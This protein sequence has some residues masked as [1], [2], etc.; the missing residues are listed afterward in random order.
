M[1]KQQ[2]EAVVLEKE[3]QEQECSCVGWHFGVCGCY[4]S[5]RGFLQYTKAYT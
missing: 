2:V 5:R 1:K 4:D 3:Q